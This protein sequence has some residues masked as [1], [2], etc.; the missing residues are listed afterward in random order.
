M[1][2]VKFSLHK[3]MPYKSDFMKN[4]D[5]VVEK[6]SLIIGRPNKFCEQEEV[7][8]ILVKLSFRH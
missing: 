1:P 5:L 6:L 2:Q 8:V 7:V 3:V 4:I